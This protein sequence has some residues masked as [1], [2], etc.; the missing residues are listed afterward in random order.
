MRA[1]GTTDTRESRD[2]RWWA[3]LLLAYV[4]SA[5]CDR[6]PEPDGPLLAEPVDEADLRSGPPGT[7]SAAVDAIVLARCAREQRC[8]NVGPGGTYRSEAEC[9]DQLRAE[10]EVDLNV[11]SCPSG[12]H[13][14]A[15]AE[16][17]HGVR[18]T[19]CSELKDTL[20]RWTECSAAEIC[21]PSHA[22]P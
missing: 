2:R 13:E 18:E 21:D 17:L 7:P 3:R 6:Q 11:L 20:Q 8:D 12:V 15:L 10:G 1:R 19:D 5:G 16:C 9:A 4:S 22:R 14:A